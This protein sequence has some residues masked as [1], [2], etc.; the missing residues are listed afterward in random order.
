[1]DNVDR[2][3]EDMRSLADLGP[4]GWMAFVVLFG[5]PVV[6]IIAWAAGY[7]WSIVAMAIFMGTV[8]GWFTYHSTEWWVPLD[9]WAWLYG[10][11]AVAL[12]WAAL[13]IAVS[14]PAGTGVRQSSGVDRR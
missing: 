2:M 1:M 13:G 5:L 6:A 4:V 11:G 7:R 8:F 12:G 9:D 14:R 3:I 10:L